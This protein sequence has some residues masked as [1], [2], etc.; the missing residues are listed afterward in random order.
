MYKKVCDV[1]TMTI[2]LAQYASILYV[3]GCS[4]QHLMGIPFHLTI[5]QTFN[6]ICISLHTTYSD[7]LL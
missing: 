5:K 2:L 4:F 6:K 3:E 1:S 7:S